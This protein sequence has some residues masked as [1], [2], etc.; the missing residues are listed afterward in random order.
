MG[1]LS[2]EVVEAWR[3]DLIKNLESLLKEVGDTR[4]VN[5]EWC[6]RVLKESSGDDLCAFTSIFGH[7]WQK[8]MID[9]GHMIPLRVVNK[10][11][12]KR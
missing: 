5:R 6:M 4:Q 1:N 10:R 2:P 8:S 11:G 3:A 12:K 7:W 9:S